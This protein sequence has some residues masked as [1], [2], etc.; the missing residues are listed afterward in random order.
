MPRC[1]VGK[2]IVPSFSK[3]ETKAEIDHYRKKLLRL[4][5]L[6]V[7]NSFPGCNPKSL[8]RHDLPC[9]GEDNFVVSLK[10][11]GVRHALFLT[12]RPGEG[13]WRC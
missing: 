12:M 4:W 8:G 9:L 13:V 2:S 1:S 10:S 3:I 11:D 6:R 7:T 5:G